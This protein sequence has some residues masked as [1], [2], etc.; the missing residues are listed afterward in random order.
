MMQIASYDPFTADHLAHIGSV[1]EQ[2]A[3][4]QNLCNI[5]GSITLTCPHR[6]MC[7]LPHLSSHFTSVQKTKTI[8]LDVRNDYEWDAGHFSH[9]AR[10]SEEVFNETPVGDMEDDL[11][12]ALRDADP[13]APIM[14]SSTACASRLRCSNLSH[15]SPTPTEPS[16]HVARHKFRSPEIFLLSSLIVV[17]EVESRAL[18][19]ADVCIIIALSFEVDKHRS[20]NRLFHLTTPSDE[21]LSLTLGASCAIALPL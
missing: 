8:V 20:K 12:L 18:L 7:P 11:P 3:C 13:A 17:M 9:A 4:L 2:K 1:L 14:V 15:G 16:T 5:I 21:D 19:V 10:P 6:V